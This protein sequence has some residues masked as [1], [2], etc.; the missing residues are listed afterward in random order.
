MKAHQQMKNLHP[1]ESFQK[2]NLDDLTDLIVQDKNFDFQEN[3]FSEGVVLKIRTA[4]SPC[5]SI[6]LLYLYLRDNI[7]EVTL[8]ETYQTTFIR[9][10]SLC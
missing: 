7:I 9:Q 3:I 5:N 1:S 2:N 10:K 4:N 8:S 6:D